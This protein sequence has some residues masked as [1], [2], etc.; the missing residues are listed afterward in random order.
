MRPEPKLIGIAAAL[1]WSQLASAEESFVACPVETLATEVVSE[2][3]SEWWATPQRGGL[4]G[5]EVR[6]IG[7]TATLVC[8]YQGFAA[9]VPVMRE[10]PAN[11][12]SCAP[13]EG[14][15]ICSTTDDLSGRSLM[16]V[17]PAGTAAPAQPAEQKVAGR[18]SVP[19]PTV[20]P[21]KPTTGSAKDA[22]P[23]DGGR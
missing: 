8:S 4:V 7:G 10:M 21:P 9:S 5:T 2:L 22:K 23:G 1:A 11:V 19:A 14:G 3:P 15:F 20:Q 16:P 18:V 17:G 13:A 6:T 12:A